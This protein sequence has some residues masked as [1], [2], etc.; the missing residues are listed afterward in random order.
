MAY[1]SGRTFQGKV[2]CHSGAFSGQV[3]PPVQDLGEVFNI[4]PWFKPALVLISLQFFEF[5]ELSPVSS[6]Q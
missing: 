1:H 2:S 3:V 6:L 5:M 4:C